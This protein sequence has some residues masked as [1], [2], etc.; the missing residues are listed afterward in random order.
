MDMSDNSNRRRVVITGIGAVTA[1]GIGARGLWEGIQSGRSGITEI[2]AFDTAAFR[3]KVAGQVHGF[4]AG[5]F[6]SKKNRKRLD[7]FASFAVAAGR[8]A[9]EDAGV[10]LS[11]NGDAGI[12]MG[13]ALGG[14]GFAEE[15]HDVYRDRGLDRVHPALALLVFGASSSCHMAI[16]LGLKGP[17]LTNSNSCSSGT[18]AV[19]EAYEMIM[20]G[21][22]GMILAGGCET[23]LYPLTFGSFTIIKA[24]TARNDEPGRACRPF[25]MQRDGFVMGEGA[26]VLVMEEMGRALD[27]GAK[28][29]AE[30]MGYGLTNDAYHM[31][32]SRPGGECAA[33]AMNIALAKAG[34]TPADI[35]YINAHGSSTPINDKHETEAIKL[36]FGTH[37]YNIPVS[38]TKPFHA[39]PLGATG[40]IEA[41][42]C[43]L[44][45]HD[46]YLPPTLNLDTPDPDC[47]LD[48][49]P[50]VGRA[51]KVDYV[52]SNS[53]GFGGMN[54]A[55][56]LGR[57]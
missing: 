21:R 35:G 25:D 15:Q 31:T 20:S 57:V 6:V 40:A 14:L 49:I 39:H 53:F 26:A 51:R 10:D 45:I 28:I 19:G 34:L 44:A 56:V 54:A 4:E 41:A 27:R 5:E 11:A 16:E 37:A 1:A 42:I 13:S 46:G 48:Y 29:Y 18:I 43:A 3:T 47:D 12:V 55:L 52:L 32:S 23:P 33:R 36:T 38:G 30:V 8:M 17:N 22:A 24:M 50:N 9:V 2:T 7:R